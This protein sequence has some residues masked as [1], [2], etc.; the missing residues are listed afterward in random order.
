MPFPS[1]D[2]L[3]NHYSGQSKVALEWG[4]C[5]DNR[6][7]EEDFEEQKSGKMW[8]TSGMKEKEQK[9]TRE[10]CAVSLSD[11]NTITSYCCNQLVQLQSITTFIL[12]YC[13]DQE[14]AIVGSKPK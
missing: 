7:P 1:C 9:G 3:F 14:T 2:Q 11:Y 6:R 12:E 4:Q 10:A 5:R 8:E 13:F